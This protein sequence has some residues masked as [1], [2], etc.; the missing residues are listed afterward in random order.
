MGWTSWVIGL[1]GVPRNLQEVVLK[2][3]GIS[4]LSLTG[5]LAFLGLPTLPLWWFIWIILPVLKL[6][7]WIAVQYGYWP[8]EILKK[9][10]GSQSDEDDKGRDVDTR[11]SAEE[12][13]GDPNDKFK[14]D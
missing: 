14:S 6:L 7:K 2:Y 12:T 13:T 4:S 1:F 9:N 10:K 5:V 3:F 11:T 8:P